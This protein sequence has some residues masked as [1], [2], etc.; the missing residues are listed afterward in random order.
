M[1]PTRDDRVRDGL[2]AFMAL[3]NEPYRTPE[4]LA[5]PGMPFQ[6]SSPYPTQPES[7]A[8]HAGALDQAI[9]AAGLTDEQTKELKLGRGSPES[10]HAVTQSLIDAGALPPAYVGDLSARIRVMMFT[11]GIGID[12][13]GYVQEAYLR[14]MHI[15]RS[16]A[17]FKS[18]DKED[19][20]TLGTSGYQ[21]IADIA[22][23][24]PGDM[25]SLG[26][27]GS[28][29]SG[30]E[31][32]HRAIVYDQHLAT[33]QE[34]DA[35]RGWGPGGAAL[36]GGGP[37]RVLQIDSSWGGNGDP[38]RGGA[39][40][41]TWWYNETTGDWGSLRSAEDGEP[42]IVE[43]ARSPLRHPFAPP[44]GVYRGQRP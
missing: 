4:G 30:H 13:A 23:V 21:R 27:P 31:P 42:P 41:D 12:C 5:W 15:D 39:R 22:A 16:A 36:A 40:R 35:L 26:P 43:T 37:V 6:M 2:D 28:P 8:K 7:I 44:F 14:V 25:V 10:I 19:L 3:M 32:G 9:R 33:D 29:A 34:L 18:A 11:F 38:L 24:R 20:S 17:H 1:G